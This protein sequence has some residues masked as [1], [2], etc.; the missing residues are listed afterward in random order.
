[1]IRLI[2]WNM[3]GRDLWTELEGLD[4][5]VALLQEV[6]RPSPGC[7]N[8]VLPQDADVWSTAGWEARDFRPAIARLS[9]HVRLDPRR[10]TALPRAMSR[11]DWSVSRDGTIT[12]AD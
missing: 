11:G 5:D 8:E 1:M 6:R 2:S 10:T 4:A 9:D 12:A 3:A 7:A